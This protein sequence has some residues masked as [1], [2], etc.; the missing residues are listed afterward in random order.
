MVKSV[1][2]LPGHGGSLNTGLGDGLLNRGFDVSGRETIGEFKQ[3]RFM[4]QAQLIATDLSTRHWHD[5]ARVVANSYGAYLFLH[6]Q[7][8]MKPFVGK[9]LLLSPIVGQFSDDENSGLGFIPPYADR[10]LELAESG[11]YPVPKHC[12]IHVGELDW[13]S[14]PT[15]VTKLAGHLGLGVTVVPQAGHI[16]GKAYVS[17]IL[18]KWLL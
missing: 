18:D 7:S 3:L 11:T 9:V 5:D 10:L 14:N 8:L 13:Q 1:Y 15:N 17:A 16:L 12:E 2:Y 4:G 6:A